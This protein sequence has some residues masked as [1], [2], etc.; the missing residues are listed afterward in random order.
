MKLIIPRFFFNN[1]VEFQHLSLKVYVKK[2]TCSLL[3]EQYTYIYIWIGCYVRRIYT[4][5]LPASELIVS[6]YIIFAVRY[7]ISFTEYVYIWFVPWIKMC[8]ILKM[9]TITDCALAGVQLL[10]FSC[11]VVVKCALII[12]S[13]LIRKH[14]NIL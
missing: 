5:L 4:L 2:Y 14:L 9:T 7:M 11:A 10:S 8:E 12:T 13:Y 1:Y 6:V 3:S